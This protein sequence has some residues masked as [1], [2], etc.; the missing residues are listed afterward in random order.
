MQTPQRTRAQLL[1][2]CGL[3]LVCIA[4][5][6]G[7]AAHSD[8]LPLQP[9]R[10]IEFT[11]DEG[12]WLSV[13]VSAD[14]T[15][16]VFDL[17]GD[18]YTVPIG[19]GAA[20]RITSGLA[21]DAQPRFS[22]DGSRLVF[23]SDRDGW[24]NA[25]VSAPDG[26]QPRQLTH[27]RWSGGTRIE[28]PE[29]TP[30]GKSIIFTERLGPPDAGQRLVELPSDGGTPKWITHAIA[31]QAPWPDADVTPDDLQLKMAYRGPA[32]GA[33]PRFVYAAA[34]PADNRA[35]AVW[36]ILRIDRQTNQTAFVTTARA[37]MSAMRPVVS[38]NGRYLV[39]AAPTGEGTGL[40]IRNLITAQET[41]LT[42]D[43]QWTSAG[44]PGS[45]S[46]DLVPGSSFTPD[47]RALVTSLNGKIWRIDVETGQASEVPFSAN[48]KL[49]IGPLVRSAY[50]ISEEPFTARALQYPQVSPD[51]SHC[52]FTALDRVWIAALPKLTA[53]VVPRRLTNGS[54]G[55]FFPTWSPDGQYIVFA[56]WSHENAG[57]LY[58][59]RADGRGGPEALTH[60]SAFYSMPMYA[61]D[62]DEVLAVRGP[63]HAL[64]TS[65]ERGTWLGEVKLDLEL[66]RLPA[67][68]GSAQAIA[69][70]RLPSSAPWKPV[71][72]GHK[73]PHRSIERDRVYVYDPDDGLLSMHVDGTD[74]RLH[75]SSVAAGKLKA[76]EVVI[77]PSGQYALAL[78]P[79]NERPYLFTV[80][81]TLVPGSAISLTDERTNPAGVRV[82]RLSRTGVSSL[83]WTADNR[84]YLSAGAALF[85]GDSPLSSGMTAAPTFKR[86]QI[87]L[88]V[89]PDR[90]VGSLLLKNAR[91]LTMRGREVIEQGDLLIRDG[92]IAA[93][94]RA[95]SL[96]VPANVEIFD[97]SG[98]TIL[99]G[100]VDVHAHVG[101]S[102]SFGVHMTQAPRLLVEL[103][104]GV[105]ALRDPF[106]RGTDLMAYGERAAAGDLVAPRIYSVNANIMTAAFGDGAGQD[107][108]ETRE[109]L[110]YWSDYYHSETIKQYVAG[111]RRTRQLIAMAA[112][113][114]GL[115]PT[116]EGGIDT[117]IQ[118]TMAL[119]GYGAVEHTFPLQP[120]FRDVTRLYALSGTILAPTL[121]VSLGW[122]SFLAD[123]DLAAEPKL[124]RLV[125]QESIEYMVSRVSNRESMWVDAAAVRAHAAVAAQIVD[126]GGCVALGSHGNIPG[127][128]AHYELEYLAAGGMANYDVLRV[129]T[130]CGAASIGHE[131][132]FGSIEAGKLADLQILERN[133]LDDIRNSRSIRYVMKGGRLFDANSLDEVWPRRRPLQRTH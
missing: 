60:D 70:H 67:N 98:A 48:V 42:R 111:G 97:L 64:Q 114:Q 79:Q 58:R 106:G 96:A 45:D 84:P 66:V 44:V 81:G 25:W 87:E 53:T 12:T 37:G 2:A 82:W 123:E 94:D 132:D 78:L 116:N 110:R 85:I 119:D 127:L 72:F 109:L 76:A 75:L 107:L 125:P 55:E 16:V 61:P 101:Y 115:T 47:S 29:W 50:S 8:G 92:R 22:P 95:G 34:R 83:G 117:A 19:G 9:T 18:L 7:T 93:V 124:Q 38:P 51:G 108:D 52:V 129:G 43:P 63:A 122:Q 99:P 133:P 130:I 80:P 86:V 126:A 24:V 31:R 4:R 90:A 49:A 112:R 26:S 105:T 120:V 3:A 71:A 30:D 121:G 102:I 36:Q 131:K 21:F 88:K 62:G 33:D 35:G 54:V 73:R 41:W 100:Y 128:G 39:F 23:T 91:L 68:G 32:F 15:A 103:A 40:R 104:Y 1:R 20:L 28:S 5:A 113:E 46:R 27:Y 65:A 74:R 17:L 89:L 59:V 11:T 56:T 77:S 118:L 69:E 10:T 6:G 57:A 13:D 14:G